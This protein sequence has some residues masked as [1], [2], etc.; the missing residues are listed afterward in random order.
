M[1]GSWIPGGN[2]IFFWSCVCQWSSRCDAHMTHEIWNMAGTCAWQ[3]KKNWDVLQFSTGRDTFIPMEP[4]KL[5]LIC[6]AY[7]CNPAHPWKNWNPPD[8]ERCHCLVVC[9]LLNQVRRQIGCVF[10]RMSL[11]H[12]GSLAYETDLVWASWEPQQMCRKME[13]WYVKTLFLVNYFKIIGCYSE[14][15]AV[16]PDGRSQ[17][18]GGAASI[19][20]EMRLRSVEAEKQHCRAKGRCGLLSRRWCRESLW[21]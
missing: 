13:F 11:N 5:S 7:S 19:K 14:D 9:C 2:S 8:R 16:V 17:A 15:D 3:R 12:V 18:G 4:R 21:K 20:A 1:G 10:I 6:M